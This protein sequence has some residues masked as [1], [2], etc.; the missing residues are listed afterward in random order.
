MGCVTREEVE[1][2]SCGRI[3]RKNELQYD[4]PEGRIC[5]GCYKGKEPRQTTPL[6]ETPK[7][8][9]TFKDE[10][11]LSAI[12]V[13][14]SGLFG[15]KH[16]TLF[17]TENRIIVAKRG[18][19]LAGTLGI[20]GGAITAVA[21]AA[22]DSYKAG[23]KGEELAGLSV[24]SILKADKNNFAIDNS[25]LVRVELKKLAMKVETKKKKYKYIA[26]GIPGMKPKS[27]W[28]GIPIEEYVNVLKQ[29]VAPE[30]LVIK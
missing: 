1:C 6:E 27:R 9:E 12:N 16:L 17:F 10:K 18:G 19:G 11:V 25:E 23:K 26:E 20:F 24:E 2:K 7:M 14:G 13:W 29:C 3:I 8:P 22:Y 15:T 5:L 28:K 21:G 4:S 30:K